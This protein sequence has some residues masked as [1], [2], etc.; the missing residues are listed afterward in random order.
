MNRLSVMM[1]LLLGCILSG[2]GKVDPDY[3][4]VN[5]DQR[6][7]NVLVIGNSYG[8]DAFSYVPFIIENVC[9]KL[10]VKFW[11]LY[12]GNSTIADHEDYFRRDDHQY[13]L[14]RYD[15]GAGRW[16]SVSGYSS[17]SA[18]TS[19]DWDL[20]V[21]HQ[22]S[23]QAGNYKAMASTLDSFLSQLRSVSDAPIAWLQVPTLPTT[24]SHYYSGLY[25]DICKTCEKV[26]EDTYAD[27]VIPCGT[28]VESAKHTELNELGDY[29]ELS[30][31]GVHLQE[32]I[33]CLLE[34]YTSAQFIMDFAGLGA[35]VMDCTL[36]VTDAWLEEKGIPRR[37]GAATGTS[38]ADNY[39]KAKIS[40]INAIEHP[41]EILPIEK[42]LTRIYGQ[43]YQRHHVTRALWSQGTV[44]HMAGEGSHEKE[45]ENLPGP[46][47]P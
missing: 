18:V 16:L 41:Y 26:V 27:Y 36:E 45:H 47:R 17:R 12:I 15:T 32:G 2:C 3:R 28:A 6:D 24:N 40:A 5:T 9:P 14:Y 38:D 20:I 42:T 22:V 21:T 43:H 13:T 39:I 8:P 30:A 23:S 35:S 29:G 31:D 10:E 46:S 19:L 34:S 25:D 1:L 11:I 7:V 33:P 37:N 44:E 4:S